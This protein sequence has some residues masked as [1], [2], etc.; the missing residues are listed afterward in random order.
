MRYVAAMTPV[1]EHQSK[2]QM[3]AVVLF[4]SLTARLDIFEQSRK[5]DN[6]DFEKYVSTRTYQ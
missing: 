5:C 6:D 2:L 3:C 1:T 4:A